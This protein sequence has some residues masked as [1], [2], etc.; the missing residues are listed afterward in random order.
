LIAINAAPADPVFSP[1]YRRKQMPAETVIVLAA[2]LSVF[3][4][5]A[6]VMLRACRQTERILREKA[7]LTAAE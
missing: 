4:F 1:S 6:V 2:V 3:A 7:R 5:F